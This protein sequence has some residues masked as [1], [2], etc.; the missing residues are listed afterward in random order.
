MVAGL[1][2][3]MISRVS[4]SVKYS[5]GGFMTVLLFLNIG[6]YYASREMYYSYRFVFFRPSIF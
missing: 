2:S 3:F 5:F 6:A 4:K 1:T